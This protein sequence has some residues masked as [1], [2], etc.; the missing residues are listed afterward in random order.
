MTPVSTPGSTKARASEG[1]DE[2]PRGQQAESDS[3]SEVDG[4]QVA[5]VLKKIGF[6]DVEYGSRL[7]LE[8]CQKVV[9][10][11]TKRVEGLEDVAKK[12]GGPDVTNQQSVSES[13]KLSVQHLTMNS[14][15]IR[16]KAQDLMK[17]LQDTGDKIDAGYVEALMQGFTKE[18]GTEDAA[19]V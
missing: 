7:Q 1:A 2:P 16:G 12:L 4:G 13:Q 6:P 15:R 8:T 18:P 10:C 5:K 11:I 9:K 19:F 14:C 3:E 17:R